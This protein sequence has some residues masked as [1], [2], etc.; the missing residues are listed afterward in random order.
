MAPPVFD[1]LGSCATLAGMR[2]LLNLLL[3]LRAAE[4]RSRQFRERSPDLKTIERTQCVACGSSDLQ[5]L[6]CRRTREVMLQLALC[7]GCGL[8]FANPMLTDAAKLRLQPDVRR[9]HRSRSS[10]LCDQRAL[11]R[12][13]RRAARWD[14]RLR[15]SCRP[16][17]EFSR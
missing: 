1:L 13:R 10:E 17:A 14:T 11:Q 15:P 7:L 8:V 4:I 2:R 12:S 3:E 9:L 5:S 16:A 6:G